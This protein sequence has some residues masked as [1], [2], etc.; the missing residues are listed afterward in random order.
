MVLQGEVQY[1]EV[2][3]ATEELVEG[4]LEEGGRSA[5]EGVEGEEEAE[6]VLGEAVQAHEVAILIFRGLQVVFGVVDRNN[7]ARRSGAPDKALR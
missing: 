5:T 7:Y 3:V 4:H 6:A 1:G 2:E